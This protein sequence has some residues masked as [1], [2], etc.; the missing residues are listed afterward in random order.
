MSLPIES[1]P[2]EARDFLDKS[3]SAGDLLIY[4][5]RRG[6]QMWLNKLRVEAVRETAKGRAVSGSNDAGRRVTVHNLQ[7]C[8]VAGSK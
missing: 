8:V 3:I 6:S 1:T 5:V 7:N 4:P 2:T